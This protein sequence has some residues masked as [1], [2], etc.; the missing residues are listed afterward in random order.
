MKGKFFEDI[1]GRTPRKLL[2]KILKV[3]FEEILSKFLKKNPSI[4]IRW[5]HEGSLCEFLEKNLLESLKDV[6]DG[7]IFDKWIS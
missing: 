7:E 2:I 1:L 6:N 4:L 3:F 5:K